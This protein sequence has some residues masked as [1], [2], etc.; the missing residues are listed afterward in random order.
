MSEERGVPVSDTSE[1]ER[2]QRRSPGSDCIGGPSQRPLVWNPFLVDVT[3]AGGSP[4]GDSESEHPRAD[5]GTA[6]PAKVG[7]A[8]KH[9]RSNDDEAHP[10]AKKRK[11][12]SDVHGGGSCVELSDA[13]LRPSGQS[14]SSS[15]PDAGAGLDGASTSAAGTQD[16]TSGGVCAPDSSCDQQSSTDDIKRFDSVAVK[17]TYRSTVSKDFTAVGSVQETGSLLPLATQ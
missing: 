5:A 10:A 14:P 3:A 8:T 4:R 9:S 2:K 17:E 6:P 15:T 16:S 11:T 12:S 13:C 1:H 7:T